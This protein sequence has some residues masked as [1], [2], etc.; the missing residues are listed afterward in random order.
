MTHSTCSSSES[1]VTVEMGMASLGED[2]ARGW[3]HSEV[4]SSPG[5][6]AIREVQSAVRKSDQ[7]VPV[8]WDQTVPVWPSC[9]R[10]DLAPCRR[11]PAHTSSG[12]SYGEGYHTV[13]HRSSPRNRGNEEVARRSGSATEIASQVSFDDIMSMYKSSL[14]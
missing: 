3:G 5:R 2:G 13:Y 12:S 8:Y 7:Q 4:W 10:A 11:K 6:C 9:K 1:G 14:M